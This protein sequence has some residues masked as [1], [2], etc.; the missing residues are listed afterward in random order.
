MINFNG[1]IHDK[2]EITPSLHNRGLHYGDALFETMKVVGRRI[3]FAEAHYF[4][5]MAS[6]RLMRME[7]P[8][9]WTP[10]FFQS[11]INKT[12]KG[13]GGHSIHRV[14]ILVWRDWGGRYT[15]HSEGVS[16]AI[17]TEALAQAPYILEDKAYKV[18]LYKDHYVNKGMLE[19]L[20]TNNKLTHVLA[21]IYAT[22]NDYQSCLLLNHAKQVVE[23]ISGNI[24][25]VKDYKIKTP[26]LSDGCLKGIMRGVLIEILA[27]HPDY[28]LSQESISPFELQKA[29]EL[30]LTNA[31]TGIQPITQYRKKQYAKKVSSELIEKLNEYEGLSP[32][33]SQDYRG[34]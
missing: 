12:L 7:I 1:T 25:L 11:E 18:D 17:F 15:P 23:S 26:P 19:Q 29:D 14:K 5:L 3:L 30:F 27:K 22:E 21:G 2:E 10:E 34:H 9:H 13:Q 6:M 4:R 16:Y 8:M 31:I 28:I 20:K 32:S 33:S 24:F